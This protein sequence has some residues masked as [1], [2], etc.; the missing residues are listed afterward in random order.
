[1]LVLHTP[2]YAEL[3]F[4]ERLLADPDTMAYNQAWG[5][6]IAFPE[7]RWAAWYDR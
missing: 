2:A 6:T 7:D 4:R 1:M 3:A 5:G